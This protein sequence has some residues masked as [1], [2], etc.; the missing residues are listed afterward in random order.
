[1]NVLQLVQEFCGKKTLPVPSIFV[2]NPDFGITQIFYLLQE[3]L[4]E[5]GKV[6]WQQQKIEKTFTTIA[7]ED[8]GE[9]STVIGAD[10]SSLIAATV[11]DKTLRRPV[12]GPVSDASWANLRSFPASG[13]IYQFKVFANH[14]H[15]FPAPPAGDSVYLIYQSKYP[16][17]GVA[18]VPKETVT[19][20]TDIFLLPEEV[21]A[22][23]LDYRWRRQKG[24]PWEADYIEYNDLKGKALQTTGMPNIH[25]DKARFK[26]TPGIWVPAGDWPH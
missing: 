13:P 16:V 26:L 18:G 2:G 8:Q 4:R 25:L 3:E 15:I 6:A 22:R 11:W 9:I 5:L 20:D 17:A 10:F 1:M 23:G 12:F 14:F 7:A 21:V 19:V 24:E